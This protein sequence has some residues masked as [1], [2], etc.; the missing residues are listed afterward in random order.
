MVKKV[1]I[2]LVSG[3]TTLKSPFLVAIE[4]FESKSPA[5]QFF[6]A[7]SAY[8]VERSHSRMK[9]MLSYSIECI[10]NKSSLL[11]GYS[12][13]KCRDDLSNYMKTVSGISMMAVMMMMMVISRAFIVA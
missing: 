3:Q 11:S 6:Y 13:Y 8:R 10:E 2:S 12:N 1:V 4:A 9:L 7:M 5:W